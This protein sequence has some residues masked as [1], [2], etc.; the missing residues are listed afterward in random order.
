MNKRRLLLTQIIAITLALTGLSLAVT[1]G[2]GSSQLCLG[3]SVFIALGLDAWSNGTGGLHYPAAIGS[4][5]YLLGFAVLGFTL[6][7][8][9]REWSWGIAIVLLLVAK[10]INIR[11]LY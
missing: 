6:P 1:W 2:R 10:I 7:K 3:D 9:S 8:R 5:V 11:F 4:L